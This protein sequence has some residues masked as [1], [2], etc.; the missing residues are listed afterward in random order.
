[1]RRMLIGVAAALA[2]G[3]AMAD[4]NDW[5]YTPE[6]HTTIA[7]ASAEGTMD[8]LNARS[9]GIDGALPATVDKWYWTFDWG[10]GDVYFGPVG[11]LLLIR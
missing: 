2:F 11:F 1:M 6:T 8:G 9:R 5:V 7:P 3:G 10:V 4:D